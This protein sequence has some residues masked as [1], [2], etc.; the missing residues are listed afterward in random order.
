MARYKNAEKLGSNI[1]VSEIVNYLEKRKGESVYEQAKFVVDTLNS[2]M[3]SA[4]ELITTAHV[5]DGM[6]TKKGVMKYID[7]ATKMVSHF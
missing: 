4:D 3:A 6:M 5:P 1:R 2:Y 7:H